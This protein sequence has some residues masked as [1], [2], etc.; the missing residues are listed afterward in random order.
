MTLIKTSFLTAI[1]TV[2]KVITLFIINKVVSIYVGPSG[3]AI[4]GQLHNFISTILTF[5]NGAITNGVVKY[6]A[7]YKNSIQIKSKFFSTALIITL[8][9]SIF[10][11]LSLVMFSSYFSK[12]ILNSNEYISVFVI[13]GFTI[14]LF[15]LNTLL[16]SVLNGEKEIKKY[17]IINIIS[18]LFSLLITSILIINLGLIGALYAMVTNQSFVFFVTLIF[19]I[20]S[21]WFK[22]EHF[23]QKIDKASLIKLSKFS[24][25]ALTSALTVPI[26]HMVVRNYIS[27][28]LSWNDAGYWQG[29]W[30]ISTMYLM[31]VTTSLS[32]YYL[33]RLSEITNNLELKKE[34]L[35]GYKIILPIVS[36]LA[37]GIYMLRELVI[38]I[39]FTD[40]FMPMLELFKWQLIGDVIKIASWL[41]GYIMIAKAMTKVFIITEILFSIL[42]IV[43]S[44]LFIRYFGLIGITYA[45]SLNYLIYFIVMIFIFRR[46]FI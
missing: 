18:S 27:E 33:P 12:I 45:F 42:F 13:F 5:A 2:I 11:G 38:E 35:N 25:M 44:I 6:T 36:I 40:K 26:S 10:T 4:I 3:L 14:V 19:V 43:L 15:S 17:V 22:W 1:S 8:F 34:I 29:I 31:I 23:K 37:F 39:A 28:N 30:Y 24:L 21:S 16:L 46:N 7:E 41:L 20:K 9:C 32:I